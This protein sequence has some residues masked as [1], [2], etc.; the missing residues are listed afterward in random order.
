MNLD[1]AF[2][3]VLANADA[4]NASLLVSGSG[5]GKSDLARQ[6]FEHKRKT[7]PHVRWGYGTIFAATHTP[8]DFVGLPWKGERT[9][10]HPVAGQ[11]PITVTVTDPSVPLWYM[12]DEG[13]PAAL[14]DKFFLVIDEYGQ[15]EADTKRAMAE[16][17]LKGGTP[18]WY[19]PPGSI[20][21]A[22]T[23][24]GSRYGVTKD[25]DF[26]ITRRCVI[27]VSG[28][29]NVW[30]KWADHPYMW[31]GKQWLTMGV[32]RAWAAAHPEQLFEEEPKEQGPWCNP[33]SLCAW[34]RYAQSI[35]AQNNG[36]IPIEDPSFM[37][38][39][40]GYV[41]MA[42]TQS[43]IG[44]LQFK[45]ELPPY[46]DIVAD[47]QNAPV[48]TRADLIML[49]AYELA[50]YA[51]PDDLGKVITY[52]NRLPK[53]MAVTFI[54][55][56]LRRDRSGFIALPAMQAWINK[57]AALVSTIHSLSAA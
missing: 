10:P 18:P 26:A 49:M 19:L 47:P 31:Q 20:R 4:G 15:G 37:E 23:N 25:F 42:I 52:I 41:G 2:K 3:H 16:V 53:D 55:A 7:E 54:V 29:V 34:D 46:V 33:R 44:H 1:Q 45:L 21:L 22:L 38:T 28:D 39:T 24:E 8:T 9:F 6:L 13:M 32:T 51:Q 40:A 14:Y 36:E 27:K 57:N 50:H 17:L 12:S 30:L 5:L 48:P 11:P 35:A 43:V 56:L